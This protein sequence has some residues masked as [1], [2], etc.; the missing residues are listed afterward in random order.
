M[1]GANQEHEIL[2]VR[3]LGRLQPKLMSFDVFGTLIS[4]RDSS[5]GA[6]QRILD[7]AGA[8]NLDVGIIFGPLEHSKAEGGLKYEFLYREEFVW[9]VSK[10]NPLA[11]RK[12]ASL[13]K[14][15]HLR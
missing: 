15:P 9:A 4:V 14:I 6:F 11:K 7:E 1:I 12:T 3:P 10:T 8:G 13:A 2:A 5:Y